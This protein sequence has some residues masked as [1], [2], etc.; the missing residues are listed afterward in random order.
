VPGVAV[1]RGRGIA[2]CLRRLGPG[3]VGLDL[4]RDGTLASGFRCRAAGR[5]PDW[6]AADVYFPARRFG[7]GRRAVRMASVRAPETIVSLVMS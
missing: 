5:S 1:T 4:C 6:R 7:P 2:A 3:A